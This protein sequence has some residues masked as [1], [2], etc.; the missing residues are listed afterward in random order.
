MANPKWPLYVINVDCALV[1]RTPKWVRGTIVA[2]ATAWLC[3]QQLHM[4]GLPILSD[5]LQP[6]GF[7]PAAC[8]CESPPCSTGYAS[9]FMTLLSGLC[10][11]GF[12]Y[13]ITAG[14]A[15]ALRA[16]KAVVEASV[17]TT[18]DIAQCLA[19]FDL[20]A[21]EALL[22][23]S[24]AKPLPRKLR[25][26]L[27]HLLNNLRLYRPYLPCE[28]FHDDCT[29][30]PRLL[31]E[32]NAHDTAPMAQV[33]GLLDRVVTLAFTDIRGSTSL[34]EAS[35]DA[36]VTALDLHNTAIRKALAA[37]EGYEVKTIGDAFMTAF[38]SASAAVAFGGA[39]QVALWDT[40]WP[41]DLTRPNMD[42]G[43]GVLS[44]R[45]G[46]HTGQVTV[47]R[48]TLTGRYDYFGPTVN[49]AAR[50][51]PF[52]APGAVTVTSEVLELVGGA[53]A[54]SDAFIVMPYAEVKTGKGL[55]MPMALSALLPHR[56]AETK[57]AVLRV[58][59]VKGGDTDLSR[60]PA[61][62]VV[63]FLTDGG[64]QS[65]L[66]ADAQPFEASPASPQDLAAYNVDFL[67]PPERKEGISVVSIGLTP[68]V[69]FLAGQNLVSAAAKAVGA[70]VGVVKFDFPDPA[71]LNAEKRAAERLQILYGCV[72][73]T[74]GHVTSVVNSVAWV[75]WGLHGG[76]CAQ[77]LNESTRCMLLLQQNLTEEPYSS[78][79]SG[80]RLSASQSCQPFHA[81]LATGRVSS[82]ELSVAQDGRR[83]VTL[84]GSAVEIAT[85]LC[86]TAF[87]NSMRVLVAAMGDADIDSHAEQLGHSRFVETW[88]VGK[89]SGIEV[90]Q[91]DIQSL[92]RVMDCAQEHV[93]LERSMQRAWSPPE[94]DSA[95]FER[96]VK[97]SGR[98]PSL[99]LSPQVEDL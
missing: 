5:P 40:K 66:S 24:R 42:D 44:V 74:D 43:Y 21:A 11:F 75:S 28:L 54:L 98:R 37:H 96:G 31:R 64:V 92:G 32:S 7:V 88:N 22:F 2:V 90:F 20:T 3:V 48:N 70:C 10:V 68:N 93:C 79:G 85:A 76:A 71:A 19:Q 72:Q 1:F 16:E 25:R 17:E 29:K 9:S 77:Y 26:A 49:R 36:M 95:S 83:F 38:A 65:F 55:N 14:F 86:H 73:Q 60:L 91:L 67:S 39:S 87:R 34:W 15:A 61:R 57:E 89:Y 33:P 50:V 6:D 8:D 94:A 27:L 51:E 53:D 35:P 84:F 4:A 46:I 81:G 99:S 58:V 12:D 47:Q 30:T 41:D 59:D 13:Y 23:S 52:G 62:P 97:A 82:A 45:I 18:E 63:S 56:M 80:A 78:W 69:S